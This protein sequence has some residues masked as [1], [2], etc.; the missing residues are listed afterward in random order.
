[1]VGF[2]FSGPPMHTVNT[3]AI[4][5]FMQE[6]NAQIA[7]LRDDAN[8]NQIADHIRGMVAATM[9]QLS[10]QVSEATRN[11]AEQWQQWALG[12]ADGLAVAD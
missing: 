9:D 1:M 8:E 12:V 11:D 3:T 2:L 6:G 10:S 5:K 4:T 7:A